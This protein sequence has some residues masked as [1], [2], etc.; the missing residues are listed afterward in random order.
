MNSKIQYLIVKAQKLHK[1][2]FN[3]P[4]YAILITGIGKDQINPQLL[5]D[6]RTQPQI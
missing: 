3:N 1:P 6:N 4:E 5:V 2:N